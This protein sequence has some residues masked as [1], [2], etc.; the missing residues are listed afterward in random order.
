MTVKTVSRC[1]ARWQAD[2]LLGLGERSS[3]PE[4]DL[5]PMKALVFR[6]IVTLR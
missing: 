3:R 5:T 4:Q 2:G 1:P 6:R